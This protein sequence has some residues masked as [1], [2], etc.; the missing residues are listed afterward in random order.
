MANAPAALKSLDTNRDGKLTPDEFGAP[1]PG[2]GGAGGMQGGFG[3][4]SAPGA[5]GPPGGGG[6]PQGR[7]AME[8]PQAAADQPA[9]GVL[10]ALSTQ[11]KTASFQKNV[12]VM[13]NGTVLTV[14]SDG[15]PTHPTANFPTSYNP[16]RILKQDY[17]FAIPLEPKFAAKPTTL[18]T[19]LRGCWTVRRVERRL[20]DS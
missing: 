4:M 3:G 1:R 11:D 16:N 18:L 9:A 14:L 6:P 13:S 12:K 7:P 10:S 5:G 19:S 17:H 20:L 15:I 2:G 8:K